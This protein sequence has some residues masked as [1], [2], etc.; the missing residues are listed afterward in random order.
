MP[1][2]VRY[3][4]RS[5][6]SPLN[7]CALSYIPKAN[8]SSVKIGHMKI[9]LIRHAP[10]EYNQ[11]QL[12]NGRRDD[13]GISEAGRAQLAEMLEN[14]SS[15]DFDV[16]Y[17]SPMTRATETA[18]AIAD[19]YGKKIQIDEDLIEVGLGSFEGQGWDATIPDFGQN[20]SGVLSSCEYDFIPYGG[21]SSDQVK[22]RVQH[23]FKILRQ[24]PEQKPLIVS[25]G[26]V[27]RMMYLLATGEKSG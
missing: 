8:A 12:I 7:S 20:S 14:L 10:T 9:L 15:V 2:A 13:D 26:G 27:M 6:S 16:I 21:E 17:C 22:A 1:Q 19:R 11:K 4:K 24:N 5:E 25:H 23:F 18:Q 3:K